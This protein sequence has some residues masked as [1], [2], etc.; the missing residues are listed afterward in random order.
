MSHTPHAPEQNEAVSSKWCK[1]CKRML[2]IGCAC[3]MTFAEKMRSQSLVL[4]GNF[5]A[6]RG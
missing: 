3:G 5:R 1:A 4:P 6:V 2:G